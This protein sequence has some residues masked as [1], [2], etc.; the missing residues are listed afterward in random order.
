MQ[1]IVEISM[2]A[3]MRNNTVYKQKFPSNASSQRLQILAD[4]IGAAL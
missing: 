4:A 3:H 2:A 1:R